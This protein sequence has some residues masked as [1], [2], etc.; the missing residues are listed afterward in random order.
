VDLR[1]EQGHLHG[2]VLPDGRLEVSCRSRFCGA[3]RGVV[4][5]HRFDLSTGEVTTKRYRDPVN[6]KEQKEEQ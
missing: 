1:C 3:G 4:V 2:I 6:N 5:L